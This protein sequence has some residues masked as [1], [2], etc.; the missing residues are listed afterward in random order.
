MKIEQFTNVSNFMK[1]AFKPNSLNQ[2]LAISGLAIGVAASISAAPA[3][4]VLLNNGQLTFSGGTSDF[5]SQVAPAA[6]D[7]FSVTFN[8]DSAAFV[9]TGG[10]TGAFSSAFPVT[11]AIY[12]LSPS[13]G[14][15]RFLSSMS[16]STFDYEL[17][18]SLS[19]PFSFANGVNL[20]IAPGSTFRGSFNNIN[21]GVNF[22]ILSS[23]GS[24]VSNAD[25]SVPIEGLSFGFGEIPNVAV[26]AYN[27]S[28]ST[29]PVPEPFTII[30]TI[31]GGTAAFRMRKKLS[32]SAKN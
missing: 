11:P 26:G 13:T 6:G 24:F 14:N 29:T 8:P 10:A 30:G 12:N 3:Q 9:P 5:F 28:V 21:S 22:G 7:T 19:L 32:S 31:V 17:T 1:A 20:T 4:A 2:L 27:I 25:G 15:F 16:P 18:S 23:V